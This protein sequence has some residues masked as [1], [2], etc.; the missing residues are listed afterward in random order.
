[1]FYTL[2]ISGLDFQAIG[3]QI[4]TSMKHLSNS[5]VFGLDVNKRVSTDY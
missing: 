4:M 3:N 1:M 2:S 5:E